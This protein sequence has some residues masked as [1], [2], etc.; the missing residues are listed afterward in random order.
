MFCG[1]SCLLFS[2]TS[3][4]RERNAEVCLCLLAGEIPKK[5][6]PPEIP[7][8]QI[9]AEI[10]QLRVLASGFKRWRG[11]SYSAVFCTCHNCGVFRLMVLF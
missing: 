10:L 4:H 2:V 7:L 1:I 9:C 5:Y 3:A 8:A 11:I 6:D